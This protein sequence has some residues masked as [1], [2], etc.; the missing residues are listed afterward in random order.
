MNQTTIDAIAALLWDYLKRDREHPDRRH[1]GFGTKTKEG[2]ALSVARCI[3]ENK[4]TE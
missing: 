3:E 4:G 2:L 1:T